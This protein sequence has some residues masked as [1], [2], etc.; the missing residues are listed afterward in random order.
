MDLRSTSMEELRRLEDFLRDAVSDAWNEVPLPYRKGKSSGWKVNYTIECIGDRPASE[1]PEDARILQV[2][3]A[4]DAHLG[5]KSV[6][7]VASTDANI[8]LSLGIEAT[9]IGTGGD[10]GG[11][12]TLREWYDCTN[13][14]LGLKRI[15]LALLAL[16]GVNE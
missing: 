6:P 3:R 1:L 15:L 12:H 5:I 14:D 4:V 9:T 7:R 2:V 16:T 8:P 13:R 11:A 10:G